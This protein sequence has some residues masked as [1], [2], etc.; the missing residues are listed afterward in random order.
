MNPQTKRQQFEILRGQ[1]DLDRSTFI[2][3]WRDLS[4]YILPRRARFSV[5]DANRGER[6]NKNIIDSTA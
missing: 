6:K 1:L 3:H 4:D 2:P 5:T